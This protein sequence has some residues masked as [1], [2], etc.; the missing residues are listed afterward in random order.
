MLT[1]PRNASRTWAKR[2]LAGKSGRVNLLAWWQADGLD[3]SN[4][5]GVSLLQNRDTNVD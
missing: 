5:G 4:L 1:A 3:G 2:P